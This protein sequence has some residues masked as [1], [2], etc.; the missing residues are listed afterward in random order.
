[1]S[2]Y[3]ETYAN[4]E[5]RLNDWLQVSGGSV[6]NLALDL[7]N[8]AQDSLWE[9]DNWQ[10]LVKEQDLTLTDNACSLPA[11]F[12][13]VIAVGHDSDGDG[14]M[15]FWYFQDSPHADTGYKIRDTFTKAAGHSWTITFFTSPSNTVTLIYQVVLSDFE[16]SETAEYSF[17]PAD[18]L[19][20]EAQYIHLVDSGQVDANEH[21]AL[22]S[23]RWEKLTDYWQAHQYRNVDMR[24][25]QLDTHGDP[26]ATEQYSMD[27]ASDGLDV[28]DHDPDYDLG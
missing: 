26:I 3:N 16:D 10:Q 1:M 22:V 21:K 25:V 8:R 13:K 15:D 2:Y 24:M 9:F 14:K 7:L 28:G 19:L 20:L 27:G 23:R 11:D 18:L 17:F 12:G 4:I 5:N 6:S